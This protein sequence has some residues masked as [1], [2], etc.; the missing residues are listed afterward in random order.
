MNSGDIEKVRRLVFQH[1]KNPNTRR[2]LSGVF[3]VVRL[4][5]LVWV[6]CQSSLSPGALS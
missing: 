2:G 1:V 5:V 4:V 3:R 6:R